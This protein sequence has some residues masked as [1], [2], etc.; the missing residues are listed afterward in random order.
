[1]TA[2]SDLR[3]LDAQLRLEQSNLK[4]FLKNHWKYPPYVIKLKIESV[5]RI[6]EKMAKKIADENKKP[7]RKRATYKG[8]CNVAIPA[9]LKEEM[10][11][12]IENS[13]DV[14]VLLQDAIAQ[15]YKFSFEYDA[16]TKAHKVTMYA[17]WDDLPQAGKNLTAYAPYWLDALGVVIW[18]HV[19]LTKGDWD[20]GRD[21]QAEMFG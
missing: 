19:V 1:M 13:D 21:E 10:R 8:Y 18:K 9:E 2:S 12:F 17:A 6:V 16:T 5:S 14:E 4:R 11:S 7:E 15:G 3:H 20:K